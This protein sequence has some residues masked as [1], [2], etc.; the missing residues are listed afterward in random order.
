M[1]HSFKFIYWKV[2]CILCVK[3]PKKKRRRKRHRRSNRMEL[4][5]IQPLPTSSSLSPPNSPSPSYNTSMTTYHTIP[6]SAPYSDHLDASQVP[7]IS[8]KYALQETR[9]DFSETMSHLTSGPPIS[10]QNPTGLPQYA[11]MPPPSSATMNTVRGN[12]PP[13]LRSVSQYPPPSA[14]FATEDLDYYSSDSDSEEQEK[15]NRNVPI[16]LCIALVIG[17]ICG[18]AMLFSVWEDWTFLDSSYFCFVTL[19]TIGTI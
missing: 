10:R 8:N 14:H 15:K 3:K 18:G 5:G 6:R 4:I 19:T 17:Y 1:A 9:D 12:R 7:I 16:T 13:P 2:C 11:T